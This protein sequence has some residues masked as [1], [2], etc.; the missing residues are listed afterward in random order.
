MKLRSILILLAA[1]TL[2]FTQAPQA[3]LTISSLGPIGKVRGINRG[4]LIV[5]YTVGDDRV[6]GFTLENGT[7]E[8]I[9]VPDSIQTLLYGVEN[10]GRL[11]G[12]YFRNDHSGAHG[13]LYFHGA[14]TTLDVPGATSTIAHGINDPQQIVGEFRDKNGQVHGFFYDR[15]SFSTIDAPGAVRTILEGLNNPGDMVGHFTGADGHEHGFMQD[16]K[17]VNR[18]IDVPFPGVTDTFLY[19]INSSAVIVGAYI[20]GTGTHGFLDSNGVFTSVDA[21]G[22]PPGVGTLVPGI[23]DKGEVVVSGAT[24]GLG[25]PTPE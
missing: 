24:A 22:T 5:G 23:N 9:E 7:V 25:L 19:G 4:R 1:A 17:G 10:N 2:G 21:P 14:V 13:L 8:E 3:P 16:S 6:H 12:A 18:T 11:V 15:G 20:D